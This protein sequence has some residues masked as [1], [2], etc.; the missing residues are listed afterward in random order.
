M[1]NKHQSQV[2]QNKMLTEINHTIV[3]ILAVYL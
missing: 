3:N 2:I 1:N